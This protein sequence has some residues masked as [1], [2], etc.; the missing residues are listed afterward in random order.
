MGTLIQHNNGPL[1]LHCIF[2]IIRYIIF[3]LWTLKIKFYKEKTKTKNDARH[4]DILAVYTACWRFKKGTQISDGRSLVPAVTI[5][6][7]Q[8]M[9]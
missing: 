4:Y 7:D 1:Y 9:R 2:I 6:S 3:L 8:S 5:P